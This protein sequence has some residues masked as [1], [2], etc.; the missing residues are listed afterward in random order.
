[1]ADIKKMFDNVE[2]AIVA[3]DPEFNVIYANERCKKVFKELLNEE[4]FVGTNMSACHKPETM[5]KLKVLYQ[6]YRD[7]KKPLDYYIMDIPG[8]KATIVSVPFYDGDDLAGVVEF[9]FESSLA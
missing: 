3:S 6:E 9:V 8:G 1:M 5:E 4:N 7:K 2:V